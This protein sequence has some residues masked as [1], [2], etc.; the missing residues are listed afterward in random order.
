[1][2]VIA[3][4]LQFSPCLEKHVTHIFRR[5]DLQ[6]L[7]SEIQQGETRYAEIFSFTSNRFSVHLLLLFSPLLSFSISKPELS[8][9]P[10]LR[11]L[12]KLNHDQMAGE[13]QGLLPN[14][15]VV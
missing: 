8:S 9:V 5:E 2:R 14:V 12:A 10:N 1:M 7:V 13:P 6:K 11:I 4:H 15:T 3:L